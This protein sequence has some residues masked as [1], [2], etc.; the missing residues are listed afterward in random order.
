M[1]KDVVVR[2][3]IQ[4]LLLPKRE[5][6]ENPGFII[7]KID[8]NKNRE[9]FLPER[10]FI[11]LETKIKKNFSYR[12]GKIYGY[13]YSSICNFPNIKMQ[14]RKKLLSFVYF[15]VKAVES[16]YAGSLSHKTDMSSKKFRLKMKEF[17][18]CRKNGLGYIMSEGGIAG[19]WAWIVQDPTI[20]AV[21]PKC[22]G[23]GDRVCEVIAAPYN[24][25]VQQGYEPIRC[26]KLETIE[27][28]EDYEEFNKIRPTTWATNSLEDLINAGFF[29]Y[30]HGQITYKGER[31]FLCEASFMYIL[32]KE[33]KKVKN[34]LD[35]LRQ[36]S[37]DFGKKLSE[38]SGKQEPCKFITDFFPALDLKS[39]L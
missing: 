23:R 34:G 10:L 30:K 36:V 9:I 31:F 17:I 19:I 18:I 14:H 1:I 33:L 39:I 3:F 12:I 16:I 21:Q 35:V 26:T 13:G 24:Y 38:I 15:L 22:Q 6:I 29:E 8:S 5:D 27:L 20:E 28:T 25:L 11:N 37:F 4:N 2:W 7:E 32:E